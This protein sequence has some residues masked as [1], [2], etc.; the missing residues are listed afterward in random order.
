MYKNIGFVKAALISKVRKHS[1]SIRL[2]IEQS[3]NIN[4]DRIEEVLDGINIVNDDIN[5]SNISKL[6]CNTNYS[7]DYIILK[8]KIQHKSLLTLIIT[9]YNSHVPR[10]CDNNCNIIVI[11][12]YPINN[13]FSF[14]K[15]I[16]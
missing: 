15:S 14:G 8:L 10:I 12:C 1:K 5:L 3:N 2:G 11:L 9:K 13:Q 16:I 7:L 6:K 4:E